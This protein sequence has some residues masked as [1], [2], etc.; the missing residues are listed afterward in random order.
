V[1][2]YIV[3]QFSKNVKFGVDCG[4]SIYGF[5]FLY[6]G[7]HLVRGMFGLSKARAL[8]KGA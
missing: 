1:P 4:N 3:V 2:W 5:R 6:I 8:I 7:V